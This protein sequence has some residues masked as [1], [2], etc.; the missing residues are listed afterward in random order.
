MTE[1]SI[2][3]NQ[4]KVNYLDEGNGSPIL[5]IHGW[6]ACKES[7]IPLINALRK[8]YRLIVADLPGYG[9]SEE[10]NQ[11]HLIENYIEF[12]KLFTQK[13]KLKKLHVMGA[14]LGG[15]LALLYAIQNPSSTSKVIV[16]APVFY[17]K[18]LLT[19]PT[20][21]AVCF[22]PIFKRPIKFFSSFEIIQNQYHQFFINYAVRKKIPKIEGRI[23]QRHGKETNQIVGI[24]I[25][26]LKNKTST[27]AWVESGVSILGIN[28]KDKLRHLPNKTLILWGNE[29]KV[30]DKKWGPKLKNLL[31]NSK[32]SEIPNASH[33]AI[34]E[35]PRTIAREI[36]KFL[37]AN[38]K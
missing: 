10:L 11:E 16:Q 28:L 22:W 9:N 34:I 13:L 25:D 2:L 35:K 33:F 30:I 8:K 27:K 4:K 17:W 26:K 12:L 1:K 14:S 5:L 20:L 38:N 36:K 19:F 18:Q 23:S 29:D 21:P 24:V 15:T 3:I 7:F 6:S 32:C 37:S 31:P